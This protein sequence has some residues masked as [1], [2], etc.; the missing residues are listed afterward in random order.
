MDKSDVLL[1]V[2][3]VDGMQASKMQASHMKAN[4][5]E[6]DALLLHDYAMEATNAGNEK[7]HLDQVDDSPPNTPTKGSH[8]RK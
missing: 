3:K 6:V 1:T 8:V 4:N 7:R 2:T 5:K